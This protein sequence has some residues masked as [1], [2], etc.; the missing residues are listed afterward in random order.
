M[1]NWSGILINFVYYLVALLATLTVHE[2]SHA[3]VAYYLGDPTAKSEGRISLNPIRHLDLVGSMLFLITYFIGSGIGWGKPVPVNPRNFKKPVRDSALTALAG[4][5][6]NF[7]FAFVMA[8][9][10]KYLGEYLPQPVNTL[11]QYIFHLNIFLG[12]FNLFPFPPLDGSKILG[13]IM[14]RK[15]YEVYNNYL[16]NGVKY[17]IAIIMVDVF[18]LT[19]LLGYSVFGYVVGYLHDWLAMILLLGA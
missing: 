14:P 9:V 1:G 6:S 19:D 5:V 3:L 10:W 2:A 7:I 8:L 12:V 13:L 4:P 18:I 16:E 11:V 17:F 15:Y